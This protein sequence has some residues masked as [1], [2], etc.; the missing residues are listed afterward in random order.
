MG[1]DD[2][3]WMRR[4]SSERQREGIT[5]KRRKAFRWN[6]LH[7]FGGMVLLTVLTLTWPYLRS[8]VDRLSTP[9]PVEESIPIAEYPQDLPA[10]PSEVA[11]RS[12][13]PEASNRRSLRDCLNGGNAIDEN[14]I[15]CQ[16]GGELPRVPAP[17]NTSEPQ[18]MVSQE[19]LA[20]FQAERDQRIARQGSA[21][22][23]TQE[24]DSQWIKSWGG[25]SAIWLSGLLL[26]T[27]LTVDL[28]AGIKVGVLLSIGS[29]ERAQR[30]IFGSNAALGLHEQIE[31]AR[32]GVI[33]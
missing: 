12:T 30:Y 13:A 7:L 14:V 8:F 4:E 28:S 5:R 16:N 1:L 22:N 9:A 17:Q 3:E 18:G 33:G 26:T 25:G 15:R 29:A 20:Q 2:R 10:P 23:H 31:I 27:S 6:A 32:I 24:R 11:H 19:Y 21:Q